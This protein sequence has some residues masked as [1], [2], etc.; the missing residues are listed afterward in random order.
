VACPVH[1]ELPDEL[2][3]QRVRGGEVALF[4]IVMRR[5]NQRLFRIARAA[6]RDEAEAED[7]LQETWTVA[8]QRLG[9]LQSGARLGGW[10]FRI[11]LHEIR[12]LLR[13]RQLQEPLPREFLELRSAAPDP[14]QQTETLRL[15][16]RLVTA[17]DA[18]PIGYRTVFVLREVEG[19]STAE[20]AAAL[21]VREEAVKTRLHRAKR[22]L[23][24]EAHFWQTSQK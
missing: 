3:V 12:L 2:L 9:S 5:Y 15:R 23:Q 22:L 18:L 17:V 21:G 6:L 11:A 16:G 7:A 4:E 8:F 10:L 13:R 1:A 14:E 24:A 19:M 20:T